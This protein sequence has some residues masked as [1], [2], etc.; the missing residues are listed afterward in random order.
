MS[1]P[2]SCRA[3]AILVGVWVI[4]CLFALAGMSMPAFAHDAVQASIAVCFVPEEACASRIVAAI[5]GAQTEIRVQAYG[6][7]SPPILD[8][9]VRARGRGVDVAILLDKSNQRRTSSG[10]A[11]AAHAEIPIWIDHPSG[12]A[13]NKVIVID[14]RLVVGGSMNY[15]TSA[16]SRNAEN[17]TFTESPEVAGWFLANWSARRAV[18]STYVSGEQE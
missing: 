9:L 1:R 5:D 2:V 6:F 11:L 16:V 17:V 10:A 18:S 7:T 12:I 8:A 3:V 14:R 4:P 13:H 15:T